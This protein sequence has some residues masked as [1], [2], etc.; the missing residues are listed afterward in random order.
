[1]SETRLSRIGARLAELLEPSERTNFLRAFERCAPG[2]TLEALDQLAERLAGMTQALATALAERTLQLEIALGVLGERDKAAAEQ[3]EWDFAMELQVAGL[4]QDFPPYPDR[5]DFDVYAGMV[6]AKEVGG[7]IYDF[8]L[9]APDRFGFIVA[10]AAGK[11]LPAAIFITLARTLMRAATDRLPLPGDCLRVVNA[12]LCLN[13][14]DMMFATA[15]LAVLDTANGEL[16]FANAGHN[17]PYVLRNNGDVEV[18]PG[19]GTVALGFLPEAAYPTGRLRLS[20]GEAIVC[21]SDGVTEAID[22][23]GGLFGEPR[24]MAALAGRVGAHPSEIVAEV[25]AAVDQFIGITPV[26]DDVTVLA[27]RYNAGPALTSMRSTSA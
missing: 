5:T 26:A 7:D 14:R 3:S 18:V 16:A 2:E 23:A 17:P 10:D 27:V 9:I 6:T 21:F 19:Q 15:F 20:A 4:P 8:F 25:V 11:G 24:L 12:M 22:A 1:M 13:N